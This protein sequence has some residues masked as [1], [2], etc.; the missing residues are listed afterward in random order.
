M[1][2]E[3]RIT[4]DPLGANPYLWV[5]AEILVTPGTRKSKGSKANPASFINGIRKPP[6]IQNHGF[7]YF[8]IT[9]IL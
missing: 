4:D 2:S 1:G 7:E 5:S 9:P 6:E 8:S 3:Y